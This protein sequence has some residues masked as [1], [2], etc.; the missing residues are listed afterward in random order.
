MNPINQPITLPCRAIL[1]NRL[2]KAAMT[3][4]MSNSSYEPTEAHQNLYKIWAETGAGLLITGN[5]MIDKNHM[6]SAG[7]IFMG[8]EKM[9]PKLKD[10]SDSSKGPG[11]HIWTQISHSGRQTNR[12]VNPRPKAPS[13]IQLKKLWLFGKPQPMTES[14]IQEVIQGF[15]KAA[16][17]SQESGFTGIQIHAAHGYLLSQFLSPKTNHRTDK[18]GGSLENRSRLLLEIIRVCRKTVGNEFPIS[19]K[20][21]SSDFQRGGFTEEDSLIVVKKL[22]E[23][24]IDLLEISGGTYE[25]AAF[26]MGNDKKKE[27]TIKREAYFLD[28]AKKVR[29]V[30]DV[31]LM[32]TGGFRSFNFCN[33]VLGEGDCDLIGMGRPFIGNYNIMGDFLHGKIPYLENPPIRT[34]FSAFEDAAEGGYYARQLINIAEGRGLKPNLNP[35]ASSMFIVKHEFKKARQKSRK[36]K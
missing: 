25:K 36:A 27:S 22:E 7:N 2:V 18:W 13:A 20:I 9:I 24:G 28:F 31:P 3:E 5:V 14:D 30:C 33:D 1:K 21:N 8:D 15:A 19:V 16:K 34:G 17:I 29:E 12:F 26:F 10:W 6:E 11:N 4:R 35:M 23:E 32:I